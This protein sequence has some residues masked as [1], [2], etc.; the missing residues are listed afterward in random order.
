MDIALLFAPGQAIADIQQDGASLLVDKDLET[1]VVISLF[2]D[3]RA[4]P[5]DVI[6]GADRRGWWGDT[7][8][9]VNG[10]QIGSRLWE[11]RRQKQLQSV[12]NKAQ[13]FCYEALQWLIDDKVAQSVVVEAA[14]IAMYTLGI[15]VTINRPTGTA[16]FKFQYVWSQF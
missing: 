13:E 1:A 11:L 16:N 6:D 7:Y 12:V 2:S 4:A 15:H 8:A 14:I 3:R 5:D 9:T 10:D